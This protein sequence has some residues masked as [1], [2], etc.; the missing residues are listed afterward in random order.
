MF[1][2]CLR[3]RG[4][5]IEHSRQVERGILRAECHKHFKGDRQTGVDQLKLNMYENSHKEIG[6]FVL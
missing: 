1:L 3:E 5:V 6:Y 4:R 2:F